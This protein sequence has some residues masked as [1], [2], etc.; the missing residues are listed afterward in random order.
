MQNMESL[1]NTALFKMM[2]GRVNAVKNAPAVPVKDLYA[3][4]ANKMALAL[5]PHAQFLKVKEI[6]AHSDDF[7]SFI[8]SFSLYFSYIKFYKKK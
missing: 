5:H 3:Y 6:I 8:F 1:K 2:Y 7:K 4:P